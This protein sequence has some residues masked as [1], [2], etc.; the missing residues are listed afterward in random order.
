MGSKG[1]PVHRALEHGTGS[2]GMSAC[3]CVCYLN[4]EA[5][6]WTDEGFA[7]PLRHTYLL[8]GLEVRDFHLVF[9]VLGRHCLP[10]LVAYSLQDGR[11]LFMD[12][13][14]HGKKY[15]DFRAN[16]DAVSSITFSTN[17]L[18]HHMSSGAL[19][20]EVRILHLS[21]IIWLLVIKCLK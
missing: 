21:T 15:F 19:V 8:F 4:S 5:M 9:N 10:Y 6:M 1:A 16:K 14:V 20:G 12:P 7:C 2:E 17:L 13:V 18:S 3:H 11:I